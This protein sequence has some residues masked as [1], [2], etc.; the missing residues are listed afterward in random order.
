[1]VKHVNVGMMMRHPELGCSLSDHFSIEATL[2]FH[3]LP[4]E[5]SQSPTLSTEP[6]FDP[7]S[8]GPITPTATD[9]LPRPL[10]EPTP[11]PA[12][13]T[14]ADSTL[15]NGAYLQLQSPAPSLDHEPDSSS[16]AQ[17]AF[18]LRHE[19]DS[20]SSKNPPPTTYDTI[21]T[22]I[23]TYASREQSQ[24]T[25][26]ARRFFLALFASVASLVGVWFIPSGRNYISFILALVSTLGL[27]AGTVEGLMALLF[28]RSELNA[29]REFYWEVRNAKRA[30]SGGNNGENQV[31][32]NGDEDSEW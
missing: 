2:T 25:W 23:Q 21:L 18:F 20:H 1:M 11:G 10:P 4:Q 3:P 31:V 14:G 30:L 32:G 26:R 13:T 17:L 8:N 29:L 24:L 19:H 16:R 15:R 7:S 12:E 28:F 6:N 22:I 9:T 27:V 5:Q